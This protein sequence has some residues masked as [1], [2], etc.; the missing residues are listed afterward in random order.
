MTQ[1]S[2][3]KVTLV[4]FVFVYIIFPYLYFM[5]GN[6]E[7]SKQTTLPL[8]EQTNNK[9]QTNNEAIKKQSY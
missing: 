8:I 9:K 3:K 4:N 1:L 5:I 7:A 6:Q 2:C